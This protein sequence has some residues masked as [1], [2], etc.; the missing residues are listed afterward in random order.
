MFLYFSLF[1]SSLESFSYGSLSE[2]CQLAFKIHHS[3]GTLLV[4]DK[5]YLLKAIDNAIDDIPPLSRFSPI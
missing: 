4:K 1:K 2:E 3:K 5:N